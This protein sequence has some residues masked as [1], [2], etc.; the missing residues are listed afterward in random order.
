MFDRAGQINIVRS[1]INQTA[2]R[3][4][5]FSATTAIGQTNSGAIKIA[6]LHGSL[7][8]LNGQVLALQFTLSSTAGLFHTI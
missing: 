2:Y 5:G 8:C 6:K 7:A 4:N 1:A 3:P